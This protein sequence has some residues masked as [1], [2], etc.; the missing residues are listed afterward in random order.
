MFGNAVTNSNCTDVSIPSIVTGTGSHESVAKLHAMPFIFDLAK[1][2]GYTTAFV[3]SSVLHWAKFKRFFSGAA[4]DYV[5]SAEQSG[6]PLINDVAIDDS[7]AF[8]KLADFIS[9][10]DSDILAVIYP[11]AL[12][13][14]YQTVSKFAMP[15]QLTG[16]RARA[17]YIL[18]HGYRTLFDTLRKTGRLDNALVVILGDHGEFDYETAPWRSPLVRVEDYS[19]E[20]LRSI[21][22]LKMPGD[23]PAGL[24][25]AMQANARKLVANVDIAPTL[26]D[27]LGL[28]LKANLR[29]VG[30]SLLE[31][32]PDDRIAIATSTNDWRTWPRSAIAVARGHDRLVC[33]VPASCVFRRDGGS[34]GERNRQPGGKAVENALMRIVLSDPVLKRNFSQIVRQHYGLGY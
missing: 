7:V 9:A 19:P 32:I 30:Y 10:A 31:P 6:Y 17:L 18:E 21:F 26:A 27:M 28:S 11:N 29:Y 1:A 23:W 4:L 16:R 3:T 13:T 15:D 22:M 24:K 25:R 8:D 12:H 14:P 33:T 5:F 20:I 2:R 34:A